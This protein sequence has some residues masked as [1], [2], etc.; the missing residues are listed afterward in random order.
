M[1]E[2]LVNLLQDAQTITF[3]M[4]FFFNVHRVCIYDFDFDNKYWTVYTEM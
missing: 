2:V 1:M 3:I 4:H